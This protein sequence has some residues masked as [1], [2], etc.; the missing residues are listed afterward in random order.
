[1]P[2]IH[3]LNNPIRPILSAIGTFNYN[4]AKLLVPILNPLTQNDYTVKNSIE[5]A[6]IL[7]DLKFT[8]PIFLASFDVK[9]LFTNIPL[10]ETIDICIKECE[11]LNIVPFD[12]TKKEFKTFLDISV[13][14]SNFIFGDQ[15]FKQVDGVAMGSPLGP[16]LANLFLCYHEEKW[17]SD[18][19]E[20]FKPLKYSRYVDD[21]LVIFKNKEQA[22]KFLDYLNN[23]HKNISFTAE[24]EA[25]NSIPFLDICITKDEGKLLTGVY[26]KQTYTG[27]GLNYHSFVPML[28]KINS[29]KTLLHRAYNICSTWQLF[30]L[31]IE[32]LRKYFHKNCYPREVIDKH[33]KRFV[34]SKFTKQVKTEDKET[35]YIKLPFQ[36][37]FSYQLRNDMS[38]LFRKHCPDVNFRF[39]FTN[40]NTI[41]S[42]F[43]VKDPIPNA[44]CSNIVYCYKC[45]DCMSRYIGSTCRNLK[46]R[47]S[48]HMG[49]SYRT[50]TPI[51]TPSFSRIREHSMS[52]NHPI[53]EQDF[54]IKFR[55]NFTKDLRIAESLFI[56]KEKPEING[57]ELATRLAIFS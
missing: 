38:N 29:I 15:L 18:C 49:I 35:K 32:K 31:E 10:D 34:S 6:N 39:I 40:K 13:R 4:C 3:K 26:R 54:S 55:A 7:S 24:F 25:N 14:E 23:K 48:E 44:L 53:R 22:S 16:T 47:I 2:N 33:I 51:T 20:E 11:R 45:S 46:I 50:N 42:L 28:F 30:H 41:G 27:L 37:H 1:M 5:F 21:C 17:L 9:S 36:G 52:C 8:E 43:K 19:P 56:L 57:N 12:L